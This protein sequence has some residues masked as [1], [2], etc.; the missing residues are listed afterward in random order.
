MIK[1]EIQSNDTVTPSTLEVSKLRSALP[2]FFDGDGGFLM[3]K[4]QNMLKTTEVNVSQEA[5]ELNFLGKSYAKYLAGLSTE[6]VIVPD[7]EHNNRVQHA[8]SENVYI[9]GDNLDALKHLKH[10]YRNQIKCIYIDPPYNTG[11]DGFLYSDTFGFTVKD[12]VEKI[13]LDE[14][15]AQRV[16]ELQGKAS[17]SAWLTF[18]LPRLALSRELLADDGV[19]FISID[20]NEAT[21]LTQ[22][23]NEIYGESNF[24]GLLPVVMNLK[25]NQDAF[26]FAETHEYFLVVAKNKQSLKINQFLVDD[27]SLRDWSEDEYGIF[28]EADNLRATGVNAPRAK[29][30]NLWYPIFVDPT[31][32]TFYTSADDVPRSDQH[33]PVYPVN[34]AGEELSWYWRRS[35][36]NEEAHNLILKETSNGWQ[37]YKKQR[38]GIG[39]IPSTKPKSF[40]YKPEYSTS[41][42]TRK[43]QDLMD[44]K[45][46]FNGPKPVPFVRDLIQ[47]GTDKDSLVLDFFSGSATTAE[48]VFSQNALDGGSRK[49]ILVQIP[50]PIGSKE[51]AYSA[52]YR[53]IDEI[54]RERIK[55]AADK[56]RCD[57]GAPIDYGYKIFRLEQ[58]T[59]RALDTIEQFDPSQVGLFDIDPVHAFSPASGT[60]S[61]REVILTTWLNKDHQGLT[62][63]VST[64]KLDSYELAVSDKYAYI[65]DPGFN[66]PDLVKLTEMLEQGTLNIRYLV[67]LP[68]SLNFHTAR[69]IDAALSSMKN[70]QTVTLEMRY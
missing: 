41:T 46:V 40:F 53:T 32:R 3:E 30:P 27:E 24:V 59:V 16:H 1:N 45:K 7:T 14:G 15:E 56:I 58:P 69:E 21:N 2:Q 38:P 23:T 43:L 4:F 6:T 25:G 63:V 65:I 35:K 60:A 19:I 47:L 55:R 50:E 68:Y 44:G 34:P 33:V 31:A 48:A 39:D 10:S 12:L 28:K 13:G 70:N 37:L 17:H 42:A 67:C 20:E 51:V 36:V 18:M 49:F 54:G 64:V 11:N 26:G 8:K 57:T 22:L 5:Y 52:G 9:V 62:P 29:R 61:G 66:N